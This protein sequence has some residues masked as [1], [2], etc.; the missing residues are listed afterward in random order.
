VTLAGVQSLRRRKLS[1]ALR[2][3][4]V[5]ILVGPP[6]GL[7]VLGASIL[8][9][10]ILSPDVGAWAKPF[11]KFVWA[12]ILSLIL[13][14]VIGFIPALYAGVFAG[15]ARTWLDPVSPL[16]P[17]L[18]GLPLGFVFALSVERVLSLPPSIFSSWQFAIIE[19]LSCLIP[20]MVCWQLTSR[21]QM[22]QT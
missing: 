21:F 2:T 14:Y 18:I 12:A 4:L 6:I 10:D 20:T 13:S 16:F 3:V 1:T 17:I 15:I 19:V 5:F 9:P 8:V 22:K 11:G 7:I